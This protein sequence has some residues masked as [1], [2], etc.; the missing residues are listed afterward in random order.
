[1]KCRDEFI[2]RT[3]A[4][5]NLV[6]GEMLPLVAL[7]KLASFCESLL[8]AAHLRP[9]RGCADSRSRETLGLWNTHTWRPVQLF[10]RRP[11]GGASGCCHCRSPGAYRRTLDRRTRCGE[12]AASLVARFRVFHRFQALRSRARHDRSGPWRSLGHGLQP[13][14][15]TIASMPVVM[16]LACTQM[17]MTPAEALTAATINAAWSLNLAGEVG[18]LEQGKSADFVIHEASAAER[19]RTFWVP[20]GRRWCSPGESASLESDSAETQCDCAVACAAVDLRPDQ[21]R[22]SGKP[23]IARP[24]SKMSCT[25]NPWQLGI[26]LS[27]FFWTYTALLFVVGWPVDRFE[28]NMVIAIGF[29]IWS[30]ATVATGLVPG[31][32]LLLITRLVLGIGESVAFPSCSK[33]LALHVSEERR[34][35]ANGAIITGIRSGPA[36]GMFGAGLLMARYGWRPVFI[37]IGLISLVWLPAWK[38]WM[39]RRHASWAA[40]VSGALRPSPPCCA[41]SRSGAPPQATSAETTCCT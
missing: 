23:L 16:S 7:H 41:S 24:C 28:V 32:A 6:I 35:F 19:F 20:S 26:L 25:S 40:P 1:M 2:G 37:G 11:A 39:P 31:F 27:S 5:V 12:G 8:R 14:L 22:R 3:G 33:I 13:R 30:L 17:K 29:L 10:R 21:L 18:S 34:G 4:Y 9:A 15:L 36:V 38:K